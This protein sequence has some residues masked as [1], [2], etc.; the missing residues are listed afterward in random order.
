MVEEGQRRVDSSTKGDLLNQD[1]IVSNQFQDL[2]LM[3][4]KRTYL[5]AHFGKTVHDRSFHLADIMTVGGTNV[6]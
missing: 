3:R 4:V 1:Q 2:K 6:K 5:V